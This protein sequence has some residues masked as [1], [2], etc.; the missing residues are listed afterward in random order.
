MYREDVGERR[1]DPDKWIA[2]KQYDTEQELFFDFAI[3]VNDFRWVFS[4]DIMN[5]MRRYKMLKEHNIISYSNLYD[6][7]PAPFIEAIEIIE[8]NQAEARKMKS[9]D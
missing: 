9:A 8:H 2:N 4:T 7:I 5:I 3:E 1:Q 6:E